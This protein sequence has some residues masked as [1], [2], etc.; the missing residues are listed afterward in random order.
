MK[1]ETKSFEH[2]SQEV[3]KRFLFID[4]SE[5]TKTYIPLSLIMLTEYIKVKCIVELNKLMKPVLL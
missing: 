5:T 1:G 2:V 3:L 4:K